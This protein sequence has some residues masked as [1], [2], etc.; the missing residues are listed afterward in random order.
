MLKKV[1]VTGGAGYVGSKLVPALLDEDYLVKV[2]DWFLYGDTLTEHPNLTK[3]RAD[4]RDRRRVR[5]ELYESDAVIHLACISNDPSFDLD[6]QLGKSI[7]YDAFPNLVASSRDAGVKRF[8]LASSTSQYG[9]KPP[10][11]KVTED[12]SADPQTDY[13]RF[14][15]ACEQ[16]MQSHPEIVGDMEYTFVRPSTI[17]G[18]APRLRMDLVVN[19]FT[20][21]A[22]ERKKITVYNGDNVRAALNI[23]DMVEFYKLMLNAPASLVDRQAFNVSDISAP[24]RDLAHLVRNTLRDDR[25]EIE[26]EK[27]NDTRSYPVDATKA[28]ETLGFECLHGIEKAVLSIRDAYNLGK[29]AEGLSNPMYHNIKRMQ[30]IGLK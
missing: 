21:H 10:G 22:V 12:V 5:S 4:I 1:F 7:N 17:C 29:I 3:V 23:D 16:F 30:Q 19:T 11:T 6:P 27:T 13:A 8:I 24:I 15:L 18:Y 28:R 25:I 9:I 26:E 2:Y 20:G 14:K